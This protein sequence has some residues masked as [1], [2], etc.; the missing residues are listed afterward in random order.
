MDVPEEE[1]LDVFDVLDAD[2]N[3]TLQLD[4]LING[5]IKL[6]GATRRSDTIHVLLV[7]RSVQEDCHKTQAQPLEVSIH[8]AVGVSLWAS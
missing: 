3:G 5:V 7:L 1:R 4:E 2:G 6:R 8:R